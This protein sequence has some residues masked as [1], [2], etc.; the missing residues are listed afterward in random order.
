MAYLVVTGHAVHYVLFGTDDFLGR[1][2][3]GHIIILN[4]L[5]VRQ[6]SPHPADVLPAFVRG[7]IFDLVPDVPMDAV[8]QPLFSV[9]TSS[10][11]DQIDTLF[12]VA[13]IFQ[14]HVCFQPAKFP[15]INRNREFG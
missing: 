11:E 8:S 6:G 2:W 12:S 15:M 3:I 10:L 5:T 13:F 9:T 1:Q 4:R 7:D 14:V